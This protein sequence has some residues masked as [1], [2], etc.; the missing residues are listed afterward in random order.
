[1]RDVHNELVVR[2]IK[3]V[4]ILFIFL[5]IFGAAKRDLYCEAC[6]FLVQYTVPCDVSLSLVRHLLLLP[7][8]LIL[9]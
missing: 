5:V 3:T 7:L 4:I 1:M 9:C 6:Q 8:V 2:E